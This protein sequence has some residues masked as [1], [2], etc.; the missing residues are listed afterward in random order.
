MDSLRNWLERHG[1]EQYYER[2]V[3]AEVD[4]DIVAELTDADLAS[5]DLPLGARKRFL[6]AATSA[7]EQAEPAN[8]ISKSANTAG[9]ELRQLTVMFCDMVGSTEL[10]EQFDPEDLNAILRTHQELCGEIIA[11][12]QGTIARYHGDGMLVYFGY[13]TAG[14]DDAERAIRAA[15][16][17]ILETNATSVHGVTPATR[18]G[19]ATGPVLVGEI[20]GEGLAQEQS[21]VGSTPN[22]AARLQSLSTSVGVIV[23]DLTRRLAGDMFE[24]EDFGHQQLKGF[25]EPVQTWRALE[26]RAIESRFEA[27]HGRDHLLELIGREEE[28]DRLT[29]RWERASQGKGQIISLLGEAGIGKSRLTEALRVHVGNQ[30]LTEVRLFCAPGYENSTLAPFTGLIRRAAGI[31]VSDSDDRILQKIEE[32][33]GRQPETFENSARL[34]ARLLR[35]SDEVINA[36]FGPSETT[37]QQEREQTLQALEHNLLALA[38]RRP[39]LILFED[40]HWIDPTS[41]ELLERMVVSLS[42]HRALL[43][44]TARPEFNVPWPEIAH[45]TTVVLNRLDADDTRRVIDAITADTK[46]T[47]HQITQIINKADGI[48]LYAEEL[49]RAIVDEYEKGSKADA[50]DLTVPSTLQDSLMARL[51]RMA[52]VKGIIQTAAAIGR[53]FSWELLKS[54]SDRSTSE[55]S[56]SLDAL[57]SANIIRVRGEPPNATYTFKHALLQDAAFDSMLKSRRQE[58]HGH[59]AAVLARDYPHLVEAEPEQMAYHSAAAGDLEA[60][61]TYSGKAGESCVAGSAYPEAIH[62]FSLAIDHIQKLERTQS[63]LETEVEIR[64]FLGSCLIATKGYASP[65]VGRNYELALNICDELGTTPH[66]FTV[67]FGLWLYQLVCSNRAETEALANQIV[68]IARSPGYEDR[69]IASHFVTGITQSY[70]GNFAT[71]RE[72]FE[73]LLSAYDPNEHLNHLLLYS[74]D[75]GL[76][77]Y[78]QMEWIDVLSGRVQ[79]GLARELKGIELAEQVSDPLSL[80]RSHIFA[81]MRRHEIRDVEGCK[82]LAEKAISLSEQYGF[83]MWRAIARNGL[84]WSQA[85]SGA[86]AEGIT[87]IQTAIDWCHD[88]GQKLPLTYWSSFLVEVHLDNGETDKGLELIDECISMSRTNVDSLYEPELLRLKGELLLQKGDSVGAEQLFRQAIDLAHTSGAGLLALRATTS[89]GN[90]LRTVDRLAEIQDSLIS[91]INAIPEAADLPDVAA[92]RLLLAS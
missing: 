38:D 35:V 55:L 67:L 79:Q 73:Q 50:D 81:M 34:Y 49:T 30:A 85:K 69:Q 32:F 13:P 66:R 14:E 20:I 12:H 82:A 54:V 76:F 53:N 36:H 78:A 90:Y 8:N 40:L 24:Y 39:L 29:R 86:V 31:S 44:V 57:E 63:T 23:S 42:S 48:P 89:L 75:L 62:H 18:V 10:S 70:R 1:L 41:S 46:L 60:A 64:A 72:Q 43:L 26:E 2:L 25:E 58:L 92:A 51:D 88:C 80:T 91:H 74:D 5:I 61:I 65:D 27:T 3:E 59:I 19:I 68:D 84:G 7:S 37:P 21:V 28:V 45:G 71:A 77:S 33:L 11:R 9:P 4:L 22:L 56:L 16:E 87:E 6:K 52:D 47:E 15:L 83:D 17:I